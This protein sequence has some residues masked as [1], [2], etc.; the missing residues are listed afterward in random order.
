MLV[1]NNEGMIHVSTEVAAITVA[2]LAMLAGVVG[3]FVPLFMGLRKDIRGVETALRTE[4]KTEIGGLRSEMKTEMSGLRS[5][6]KTEITD[7][8]NEMN[9]GFASVRAELS[10]INGRIDLI[11]MRVDRLADAKMVSATS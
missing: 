4:I 7:L 1:N 5:E 6:M 9:D 8:R 10:S 2:T 3:V 11:N